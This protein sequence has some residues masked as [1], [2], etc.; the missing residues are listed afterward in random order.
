LLA[1]WGFRDSYFRRDGCGSASE[2]AQTLR[3]V[4]NSITACKVA[5]YPTHRSRLYS[6]LAAIEGTRLSAKS[7]PLSLA[8]LP[9][10]HQR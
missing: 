3:P 9:A 4:C 5:I 7:L 1:R 6:F 2:D 8:S 10:R